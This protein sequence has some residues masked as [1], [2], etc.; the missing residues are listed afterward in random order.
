MNAPTA[1]QLLE[2][3]ICR[4]GAAATALATVSSFE[5]DIANAPA[6]LVLMGAVHYARAEYE[7]SVGCFADAIRA[8][9]G[10]A[11]RRPFLYTNRSAA[12][13]AQGQPTDLRA[14]IADA[15][16]AIGIDATCARAHLL[17]GISLRALD[18]FAEAEAAL[19]RGLAALDGAEEAGR[20]PFA[21]VPTQKLSG[22]HRDPELHAD[23][24]AAL[25]ELEKIRAYLGETAPATDAAAS[26]SAASDAGGSAAGGS[27]GHADAASGPAA[28]SASAASPPRIAMA[29]D[30]SS[31]AAHAGVTIG[32]VG[33]GP[34][35]VALADHA[36]GSAAD[37]APTAAASDE[38]TAL[39]DWLLTRGAGGC[40]FPQLHMKSY[41]SNGRGVH[42]RCVARSSDRLASCP[43]MYLSV[44]AWRLLR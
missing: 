20:S 29:T 26:S 24:Q 14:A 27:S 15:D 21:A 34:R 37:G 1:L 44:C 31:T 25:E 22:R 36:T 8:A 28:G 4:D 35:R 39:E 17:R 41:G 30:G 12:Y 3:D 33:G 9:G 23:L 42:C 38:F 2:F 11:A 18:R 7:E 43:C 19:R 5:P 6:S 32:K 40:A 13:F 10:P 16:A